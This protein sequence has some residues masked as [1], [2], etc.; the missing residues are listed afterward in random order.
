MGRSR[1]DTHTQLL[2]VLHWPKFS[3]LLH[4]TARAAGKCNP[5]VCSE[6]KGNGLGEETQSLLRNFEGNYPLSG[7]S[8]NSCSLWNRPLFLQRQPS[9][10]MTALILEKFL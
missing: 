9:P 3:A 4:I 5:A 2:T 6:R 1:S 10:W 7:G 8:V